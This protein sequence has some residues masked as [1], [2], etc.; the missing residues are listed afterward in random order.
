MD[1]VSA[2]QEDI[3]ELVTTYAL[4]VLAIAV[5]SI[6]ALSLHC[7]CLD[8]PGSPGLT[9]QFF[10]VVG[11]LQEGMVVYTVTIFFP[12]CPESCRGNCHDDELGW[13]Y[14]VP[15]VEGMIALCWLRSSW[16]RAVVAKALRRSVNGDDDH[17]PI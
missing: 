16:N 5:W 1:T 14:L 11:G 8:L 7:C 17:D 15:A 9:V 13:F 12:Y 2:C 6:V 4:C 10:G 3:N